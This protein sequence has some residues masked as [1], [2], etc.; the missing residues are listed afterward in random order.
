[1]NLP[2]AE[3]KGYLWSKPHFPKGVAA[4]PRGIYLYVIKRDGADNISVRSMTYVK[5][6][7]GT[8]CITPVRVATLKFMV[9]ENLSAESVVSELRFASIIVF[10]TAGTT[11]A[12]TAS[13]QSLTITLQR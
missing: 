3:I 5:M 8:S 10:L 9:K 1:M 12:T 13:G 7:T 4:E 2:A 11:G 6:F